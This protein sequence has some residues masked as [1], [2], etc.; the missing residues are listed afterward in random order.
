MKLNVT[1]KRADRVWT[2]YVL[3]VSLGHKYLHFYFIKLEVT[4]GKF[5][6]AEILY[7][8]GR[9]QTCKYNCSHSSVLPTELTETKYL[10]CLLYIVVIVG[11]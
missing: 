2:R 1:L 6:A 8:Y 11:T 10:C 9:A 7:P 3:F 4:M 5:S